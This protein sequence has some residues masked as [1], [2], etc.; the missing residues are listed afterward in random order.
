MST[1][2]LVPAGNITSLIAQRTFAQNLSALNSVTVRLATGLRINA[3]SDDPSGLIASES[4]RSALASLEAETRSAQRARDVAS[5]ADGALA[6]VS[7]LLNRAEGLAVANADSTLSQA[8]RD[9]NQMEIDSINQSID[10][11]AATTTFNGTR[12]FSGDFALTAAGESVAIGSMNVGSLGEYTDGAV[13]YNLDDVATGGGAMTTSDPDT[14]SSIIEAARSEV[15]TLRG[16][17]GA[18]ISNT[19]D[20]YADSL[21]TSTENIAAAESIIRDTDYAR[22]TARFARNSVLTS[23]SLFALSASNTNAGMVMGLLGSGL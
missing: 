2:S 20:P 5:V 8:E 12:L 11:I 21:A 13:T 14:A 10:R 7:D 17:I 4:L 18:F 22:A 15:A 6:E 16:R 19:V 9:A 1:F 3:A 23:A